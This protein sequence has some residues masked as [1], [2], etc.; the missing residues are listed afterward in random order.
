M[1]VPK[2]Q[3]G[4]GNMHVVI[5]RLEKTAMRIE[6]ELERQ[7]KA[8]ERARMAMREEAGKQLAALRK[9]QKG[10]LERIRVAAVPPKRVPPAKPVA[11]KAPA[12]R[13]PVRKAA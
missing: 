7:M 9:E 12:R 3:A 1:P 6:K 2:K 4:A 8:L 13:R 10:F 11:R 5:D